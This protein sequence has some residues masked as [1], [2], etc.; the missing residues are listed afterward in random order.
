MTSQWSVSL[1][2]PLPAL[3]RPSPHYRIHRFPF[4][5]IEFNFERRSVHFSKTLLLPRRQRPKHWSY[6]CIDYTFFMFFFCGVFQCMNYCNWCLISRICWPFG[7]D[8]C[9]C[10]SGLDRFHAAGICCRV[11]LI[12]MKCIQVDVFLLL[13]PYYY[14]HYYLA[15]YLYIYYI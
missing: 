6:G 7:S 3:T 1:G 11:W 9:K 14:L 8:D 5:E 4:E 13:K 2:L 15:L 10:W 12:T